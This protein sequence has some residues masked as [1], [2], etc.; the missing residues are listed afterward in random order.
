MPLRTAKP[1]IQL[2]PRQLQLLRMVVRFQESRSYSPTLAEM[3]SEL[4]I[5]RSTTFEHIAE[6]RKKGLLSGYPNKARSLKVSSR[7]HKLLS[8]LTDQSF[9]TYSNEPGGIPLSGSVAAGVPLEAVENV[10]CRRSNVADDGQLVV[11]VV[12]E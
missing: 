2:T 4:N 7:A 12:D 9:H 6:L 8:C 11:A 1:T 3:A 5:S 10:E